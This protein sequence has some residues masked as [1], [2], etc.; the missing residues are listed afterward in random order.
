[1]SSILI[2]NQL[3]DI[4][5][6]IFA[7]RSIPA[8]EDV[9]NKLVAELEQVKTCMQDLKTIS[10]VYQNYFEKNNTSQDLQTHLTSNMADQ[11]LSSIKEK[12]S[13][14]LELIEPLNFPLPQIFS[15]K[16]DIQSS[17]PLSDPN[18][19][20]ELHLFNWLN[21]IIEKPMNPQL[22]SDLQTQEGFNELNLQATDNFLG[23]LTYGTIVDDWKYK[24]L[25]LN[26]TLDILF[27]E[28]ESKEIL[29]TLGIR[30]RNEFLTLKNGIV[31]VS[32]R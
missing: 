9:I 6:V 16:I 17:E 5:L 30:C 22:L 20:F 13:T 31:I 27:K 19:D 25:R 2:D 1:M 8:S 24:D 18:L 10:L 14:I 4:N 26:K 3:E 23:F 28:W 32:K 21:T 7:L 12:T 11:C 29:E 15:T